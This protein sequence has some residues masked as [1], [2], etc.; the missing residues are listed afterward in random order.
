[1]HRHSFVD[2][3]CRVEWYC[4]IKYD[5]SDRWAQSS[6]A[7]TRVRAFTYTVDPRVKECE[8][9]GLHEL[10]LRVTLTSEGL[11][12][13]HRCSTHRAQLCGEYT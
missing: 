4:M 5:T 11:E 7:M 13:C 1:M 9:K 6:A 2:R 10:A 8:A 3:C 12:L